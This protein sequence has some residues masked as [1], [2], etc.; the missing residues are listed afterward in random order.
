MGN[1]SEMG[2]Q[3]LLMFAYLCA[4]LVQ[5]KLAEITLC[6]HG[7]SETLHAFTG[8]VCWFAFPIGRASHW[9]EKVAGKLGEQKHQM[10]TFEG[11]MPDTLRRKGMPSAWSVSTSSRIFRSCSF[12]FCSWI[13]QSGDTATREPYHLA[14]GKI[15]V[16]S[17]K[18]PQGSLP[19]HLFRRS[20][21]KAGVWQHS[22]PPAG[23]LC[24]SARG[25][26]RLGSGWELM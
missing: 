13:V 2:I 17:A 3:S 7:K 25:Q 23:F 22:A 10:S 1:V 19:Q 11:A 6:R 8:K 14:E 21:P 5:L 9:S 20:T 12:I 15:L 26:G 24:G 16:E 4:L 18:D